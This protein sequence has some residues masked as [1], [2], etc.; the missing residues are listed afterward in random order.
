MN[1]SLRMLAQQV[2]VVCRTGFYGPSVAVV[3]INSIVSP[4]IKP[5]NYTQG[6]EIDSHIRHSDFITHFKLGELHTNE[7]F[8][9]S[10]PICLLYIYIY[11]YTR[12]YSYLYIHIH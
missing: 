10:I 6:E 8:S 7:I 4:P 9:M 1:M 2:R 3:L 5:P 11:I 12:I